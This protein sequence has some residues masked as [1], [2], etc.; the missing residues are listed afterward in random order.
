MSMCSFYKMN[1]YKLCKS[2]SSGGF[3]R[4]YLVR[5]LL[6]GKFYAAKFM[7]KSSQVNIDRH[8]SIQN[9]FI[10]HKSLK[11]PYIVEMEEY[12]ETQEFY[13]LIM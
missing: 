3:S 9:E 7:E 6:T 5:N 1:K 11:H 2:L 12:I 8:E 10:I 4:V 13:I